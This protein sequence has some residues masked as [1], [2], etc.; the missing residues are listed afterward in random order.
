MA[1]GQEDLRKIPNRVDG[2]SKVK[3]VEPLINWKDF[4]GKGDSSL[5]FWR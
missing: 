4:P 5:H 1:M 3:Y 2:I